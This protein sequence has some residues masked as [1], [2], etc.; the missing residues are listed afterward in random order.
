MKIM[1][2]DSDKQLTFDQ[3][4]RVFIDYKIDLTENEISELSRYLD[5]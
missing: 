5:D 3:F 2:D 1:D 4:R